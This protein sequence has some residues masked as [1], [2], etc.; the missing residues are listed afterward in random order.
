MFLSVESLANNRND[1]SLTVTTSFMEEC[2][3][4]AGRSGMLSLR[5]AIERSRASR[6]APS[7]HSFLL[8]FFSIKVHNA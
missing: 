4:L 3:T 1:E 5:K 6:F 2:C 8:W 7:S